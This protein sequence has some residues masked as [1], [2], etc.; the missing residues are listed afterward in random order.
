VL[1]LRRAPRPKGLFVYSILAILICCGRVS[2]QGIPS[3]GRACNGSYTGIFDGNVTVSTGQTC[4][5]TSGGIVGNAS[6][7]GG[8]LFLNQASLR[9]NV[10]VINGGRLILAMAMIG[11]NVEVNGG[12]SFSIGPSTS[13]KGNVEIHDLAAGLARNQICGT[14]VGGNLHFHDNGTAIQI[15]AASKCVGN[16][17]AGN[18][19]VQ[20]NSASTTLFNNSVGGNTQDQNNTAAALVVGNAVGGNL[21]VQN[22]SGSVTV[23][24]NNVQKSIQ[25]ENNP[26]ISAGSNE[27]KQNQGCPNTVQA[28]AFAVSNGNSVV[29]KSTGGATVLTIPLLNQQV[30]T[31]TPQGNVTDVTHQA[32]NISDDGS[33]AGV[34]SETYTVAPADI[35][36]EPSARGTFAYYSASGSLWQITAPLGT[37]FYLPLDLSERSITPDGSRVLLISTDDGN[38]SPAF[39]VYD[40]SGNP[41]YQAKGDFVEL[42][43]AQISP[44]GRY[45]LVVGVVRSNQLYQ[46]LIRVTDLTTNTSS[47]LSV[48]LATSPAPVISIAADGR[49]LILFQGTQTTLP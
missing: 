27:A 40:Q 16:S 11:G 6:V 30:V 29:F 48:N 37:P 14:N 28:S 5:F 18:L 13:I 26:A 12:S 2:A 25:C 39:S 22:N 31:P 7:D 20:N 35:D 32:A 9:G 24:F 1:V 38:T 3:S 43:Q 41:V 42:Y 19:Q 33:Y 21:Q 15:G 8:T 34:Y 23:A 49:F 47:D 36:E 10:Q 46:D 17:I 4:H 45:L 44:N